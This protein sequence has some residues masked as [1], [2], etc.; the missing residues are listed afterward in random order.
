[1]FIVLLMFKKFRKL[2]S[3]FPRSPRLMKGALITF[4]T[5]NL[6]PNVIIFQ[7]NPE[8]MTRSLQDSSGGGGGTGGDGS[9]NLEAFR[10]SP[11]NETITLEI[12]L[13]A[14]DRLQYPDQNRETVE[15]GIHPQLSSLELLLYPKSDHIRSVIESAAAGMLE[16]VPPQGPFTLF[17]W[18]R[19][20]ILPVQ[21]TK[22]DVTEE[23]FDTNLN[24]IRAKISLGL[25][26]LTY[27]DLSP[28]HPGFSIY[29]NHQISKETM[30][31]KAVATGLSSLG[32]PLNQLL[33]G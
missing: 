3:G 7:Y 11:P 25:R 10:L 30:A 29:F 8:S 20:R 33:G 14:T 26:V 24:P 17:I 28:L 13:D 31:K 22:F 12:E 32:V 21:V 2:L 9:S 1:M 16:V 5:S 4:D 19:K 6:I 18:G 23:A 15:M 27:S